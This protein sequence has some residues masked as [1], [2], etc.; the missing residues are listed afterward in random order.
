MNKVEAMKQIKQEYPGLIIEDLR[1]LG[2][3]FDSEAFL[4]NDAYVFKFPRHIRAAKNLYKEALVLRE[5]K[6]QV[7]LK[8][9]EI[10]YVGKSEQPNQLKFIAQEKIEGVPL[11]A[12]ILAT[13]TDDRKEEMA[14]ELAAFF[15]ALHRIEWKTQVN[16]LEVN[17]NT[18]AAYEYEVIKEAA[19]PLLNESV[20]QE[21]D[22]VYDKLLKQEFHYNKCLIHN[23]FGASNVYYDPVSDK[24]CGLID[25]GD[26]ALYDRDMEFV[27]LMYDYEEGFDQEFVGRI[28]DYYGMDSKDIENKLAFTEFYNQ[29]ENVYL[30]KEFGMTDLFEDS[31]A[32][33]KTG[34]KGFKENILLEDKTMY[35][36]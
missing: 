16:N 8:V 36:L 34:L 14:K 15:K 12:E 10:C 9:P 24:I 29:L 21:I 23:D 27:C 5:I 6:D 3:G 32:E 30:G 26:I 35:Y 28:L 31:V 4:L 11:D 18:K 7:P 1:Y 13:L 33:I 2:T 20:K 22:E 19:Y 25:F 17:K